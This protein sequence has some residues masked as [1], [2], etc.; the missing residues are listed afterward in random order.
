M[1]GHKGTDGVIYI[2][3]VEKKYLQPSLE[4][5][6]P[7]GLKKKNDV[8]STIK[9]EKTIREAGPSRTQGSMAEVLLVLGDGQDLLQLTVLCCC[10]DDSSLVMLFL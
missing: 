9:S 10:R 4:H 3:A 6:T 5:V 1:E 2:S 7:R 8:K